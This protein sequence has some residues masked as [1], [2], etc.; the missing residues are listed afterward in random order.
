MLFH[1]VLMSAKARVTPLRVGLTVPQS[2]L[3]GLV[4]ETRLQVRISKHY[5]PGVGSAILLGDSTCVI[6]CMEK[7]SN[8]FSPFFHSRISEAIR[9]REII[10]DHVGTQEDIFHLASK[11]NISDLATRK[12]AMAEDC[13]MGSSWQYGP[14]W[15]RTPRSTWPVSRD[16]DMNTVP[17][18]ETKS[19]I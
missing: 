5:K 10:G 19:K 2:E 12:S 13:K 4:L 3:S 18:E 11:E 14:N 7:N 8:S 1:S 9:N 17:K 16:F 6:S 15:L